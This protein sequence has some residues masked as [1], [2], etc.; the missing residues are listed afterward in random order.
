ME[1]RLG[2][3]RKGVGILFLFHLDPITKSLLQLLSQ[4]SKRIDLVS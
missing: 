3:L 2:L 1:S 4:G